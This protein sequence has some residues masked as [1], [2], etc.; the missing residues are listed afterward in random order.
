MQRVRLM[1]VLHD[2]V[3]D[4]LTAALL[5]FWFSCGTVSFGRRD[6]IILPIWFITPPSGSGERFP[7]AVGGGPSG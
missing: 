3:L 6:R 1:M 2:V 5:L 7:A 4:H